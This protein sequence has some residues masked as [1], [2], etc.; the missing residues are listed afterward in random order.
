MC[1]SSAPVFGLKS[2][3]FGS[4]VPSR[5]HSFLGS[6]L[7]RPTRFWAVLGCYVCLIGSL[8]LNR[9]L[10]YKVFLGDFYC[11]MEWDSDGV[12]SHGVEWCTESGSRTGY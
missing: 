3:F 5:R 10:G 7:G 2:R 1:G 11:V 9:T 12:L 8:G 6:L 4:G